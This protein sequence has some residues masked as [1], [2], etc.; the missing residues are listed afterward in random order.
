MIRATHTVRVAV[1][2]EAAFDV[3]GVNVYA[4]HPRWEPEVLEIRPL[5]TGPVGLGSE[6]VMVRKDGR[7]ISETVYRVTAFDPGRRIAFEHDSSQ[8]GF[9][10]TLTIE[11][12]GPD[13]AS[14]RSDVQMQPLGALRLMAPLMRLGAPRRTTRITNQ[15][16]RVVEQV[17]RAG[18]PARS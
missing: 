15:M 4:N 12:E 11:P 9:A 7:Q 6:A 5:S 17:S 8:L 16:G 2:A 1:P 13:A 14:I 10:L 3:I 18:A